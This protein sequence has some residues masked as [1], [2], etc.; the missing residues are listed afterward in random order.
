MEYKF[1]HLDCKFRIVFEREMKIN[2]QDIYTFFLDSN[3]GAN[4]LLR[5]N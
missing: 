2:D 3:D 4:Y 5:I 1:K